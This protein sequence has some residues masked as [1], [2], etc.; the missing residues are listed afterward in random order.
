M[1][2]PSEA[3]GSHMFPAGLARFLNQYYREKGM[4]V[5]D[6]EYLASVEPRDGSL[7]AKT[8]HGREMVVNGVVA[9]IGVQPNVELAH[10]RRVEGGQRHRPSTCR[11]GP[12]HPDVYAAGEVAE[13]HNPALDQ[14]I[15]RRA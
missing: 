12:A 13:F 9:G 5:L 1:V 8:G 2:F 10:C 7:L 3:I 6:G 11:C 14:R 4:E 15:A